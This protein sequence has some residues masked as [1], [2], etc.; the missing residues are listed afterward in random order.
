MTI[1]SHINRDLYPILHIKDVQLEIILLI[2]DTH[3]F[4][5]IGDIIHTAFDLGLA[6][7][8]KRVNKEMPEYDEA[9][10]KINYKSNE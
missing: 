9:Y 3:Y 4:G 6:E 10:K 2:H 8:S 5:S 1:D 7:L